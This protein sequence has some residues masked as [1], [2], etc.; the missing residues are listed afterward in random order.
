MSVDIYLVLDLSVTISQNVEVT[1]CKKVQQALTFVESFIDNVDKTEVNVKLIFAAGKP[2]LAKSKVI[3]GSVV[4]GLFQQF[5]SKLN[6]QYGLLNFWDL[7]DLILDHKTARPIEIIMLTDM[8]DEFEFDNDFRL[9]ALWRFV[10][11]SN[12]ETEGLSEKLVAVLETFSLEMGVYCGLGRGISDLNGAK[13]FPLLLCEYDTV[14]EAAKVLANEERTEKFVDIVVSPVLTLKT[15]L[16]PGIPKNLVIFYNE[17]TATTVNTSQPPTFKMIATVPTP[18]I[19]RL[20]QTS[21]IHSVIPVNN[22]KRDGF[23]CMAKTLTGVVPM[24]GILQHSSGEEC[25]L[26]AIKKN[27]DIALVLQFYPKQYV[28]LKRKEDP[29]VVIDSRFPS[30]S[31]KATDRFFWAEGTEIQ[32]D[33]NKLCRKLKRDLTP[34]GYYED[35]RAMSEFAV[36]CDFY[37]LGP[38]F[39]QLLEKRAISQDLHTNINIISTIEILRNGGFQGLLIALPKMEQ[40]A[41][42]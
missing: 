9:S 21:L 35:L 22:D 42:K 17:M 34:Q 28:N 23:L 37:D 29:D 20:S 30:V 2:V 15:K 3:S 33:V 36:A 10:L 27:E 11:L 8:V 1:K 32:Q 7:K 16:Q 13:H 24:T 40:L 26:R 25:F 6:N 18:S 39:A 38:N 19:N 4:K 41:L 12:Y 5:L 14:E 31:Y